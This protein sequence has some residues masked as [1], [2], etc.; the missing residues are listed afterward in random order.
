MQSSH[1]ST[2]EP[3]ARNPNGI[4]TSLQNNNAAALRLP[5]FQK[6]GPRQ[7]SPPLMRSLGCIFVSPCCPVTSTNG[8]SPVETYGSCSCCR[9][10]RTWTHDYS[11]RRV[12]GVVWLFSISPHHPHAS[13]TLCVWAMRTVLQRGKIRPSRLDSHLKIL[14]EGPGS[15]VLR[16]RNVR[17]WKT[18]IPT[19][20]WSVP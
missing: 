6:K 10:R 17:L 4:H 9:R 16:R 19:W 12:L 20:R 11:C 8:F 7:P 15:S 3:Q 5:A 13:H 14:W 2:F 18:C 1:V